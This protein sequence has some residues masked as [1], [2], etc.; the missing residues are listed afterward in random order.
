MNLKI[1]ISYAKISIEELYSL[2]ESFHEKRDYICDG[3]DH[4]VK[5]TLEYKNTFTFVKKRGENNERKRN[6]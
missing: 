6:K 5:Y 4:T 1:A 2:Y 3:D